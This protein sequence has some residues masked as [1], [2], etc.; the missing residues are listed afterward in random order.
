MEWLVSDARNLQAIDHKVDAHSFSPAEYEVVR[1]AIYA[2]GDL[3]YSRLIQFSERALQSG[4]A[5]LASRSTIVVDVPMI[6]V[7]IASEI[8]A[9]FANPVYCGMD[10]ITRPQ[11]G[12]S[13]VAIGINALAKRYP[14]GIFVV[15]ASQAALET[16]VELVE[17]EQ[18]KPALVIGTPAGFLEADVL[19]ARL[20]DSLVPHIRIDG[21]KGNAAVA[22]AILDGLIELAW[23]AYSREEK[24]VANSL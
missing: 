15:G 8:Q 7:G 20:Q 2:T 6:Q 24:V 18:I 13:Q 22:T 10:A 17:L 4:A 1:R 14:E 23:K 11:R 21:C 19:K 3:E 5:A 9:T 12:G 16:I